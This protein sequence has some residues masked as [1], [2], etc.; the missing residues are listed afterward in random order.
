MCNCG[1]DRTLVSADL[2][3]GQHTVLSSRVEAI[4]RVKSESTWKQH[5]VT[6][7]H[8][9]LALLGFHISQ[10]NKRR[11]RKRYMHTFQAVVKQLAEDGSRSCTQGPALQP[12][13]PRAIEA[14]HV[15]MLH[16]D[17]QSVSH[18]TGRGCPHFYLVKFLPGVQSYTHTGPGVLSNGTTTQKR[19]DATLCLHY[20]D[21]CD[22]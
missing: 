3:E 8:R 4:R 19:W 16:D 18:Q 22:L 17:S 12:T 21:L 7:A 2:N 6:R 14:D 13:P 15:C 1:T 9:L 20:D 11:A 5:R 10:R